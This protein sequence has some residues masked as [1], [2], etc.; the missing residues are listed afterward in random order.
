MPYFSG[1]LNNQVINSN[2]FNGSE[3]VTNNFNIN[4]IQIQEPS[5]STSGK[6]GSIRYSKIFLVV[7]FTNTA[8]QAPDC[9]EDSEEGECGTG[10]D[11]E[12]QSASATEDNGAE[13]PEEESGYVPKSEMADGEDGGEP[14]DERCQV[15]NEDLDEEPAAWRR[16][17]GG[18]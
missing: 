3:N 10:P 6:F 5:P 14:E 4:N 11:D 13:Q 16:L 15:D 18:K 17:R 8:P 1:S 7:E 2:L 9:C 12:G